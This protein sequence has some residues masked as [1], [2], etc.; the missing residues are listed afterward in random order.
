MLDGKYIVRCLLDNKSHSTE[1]FKTQTSVK[2]LWITNIMMPAICAA[3]DEPVPATGGWMSS[4]LNRLLKDSSIEIAVA[5]VYSGKE[6]LRKEIDGVVYYLL[7]LSGKSMD[8]YHSFLERYWQTVKDD[9][10]PDVVHVH[11]SE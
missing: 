9:F 7:P 1:I 4:S 3:M 10:V 11:G 2:V 8:K 6:Y 5:T